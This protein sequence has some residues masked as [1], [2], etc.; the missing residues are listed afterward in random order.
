MVGVLRA[1]IY[2]GFLWALVFWGFLC[3]L[4]VFSLLLPCFGF[5]WRGGD[6]DTHKQTLFQIGSGHFQREKD[7]INKILNSR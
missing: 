2:M 5:F 7:R 6:E 1:F 4:A 3:F